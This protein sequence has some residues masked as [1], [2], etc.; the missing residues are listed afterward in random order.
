MGTKF[1]EKGTCRLVKF[2]R[3]V[4]PGLTHEIV[5]ALF[6]CKKFEMFYNSDMNAEI[7]PQDMYKNEKPVKMD[8]RSFE[9]ILIA[10]KSVD[11]K[12]LDTI[13]YKHGQW[14]IE[15]ELADK[16]IESNTNTNFEK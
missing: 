5:S 10:S 11:K 3:L 7:K 13:R 12:T 4:K 2:V 1:S 15:D 14:Y 6:D 16:W 8:K 9:E